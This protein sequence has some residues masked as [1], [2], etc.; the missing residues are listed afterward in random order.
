MSAD[1][2]YNGWTNRATWLAHLWL[3]NDEATYET[4]RATVRESGLT[5]LQELVEGLADADSLGGFRADMMNAALGSIDYGEL[6]RAFKEEE[7]T[8]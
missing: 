8:A 3:T 5:A 6:W 1:T 2:T 7:A 4:A